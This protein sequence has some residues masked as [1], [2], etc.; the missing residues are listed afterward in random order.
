MIFALDL[1]AVLHHLAL[2]DPLHSEPGSERGPSFFHR[3]ICVVEDRRAG[4]PEL[5]RS[6]ARPRQAVVVAAD[7]G[8]VLWRPH[9]DKLEL[10][11]VAHMRLE[12]F[13][14]LS[15]ITGRPA[16]TIDLAQ[17]VLCRYLAVLD[18]DILEHQVREAKLAGEHVHRVVVV[19]RFKDRLDDL[20]APL[21]RTVR[22]SARAIHLE[23]GAGW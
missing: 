9:R 1:L 15:A 17:E 4:V 7:F 23:A 8:V 5:R 11:L 16:A 19:L 18:L 21:Q 2:D 6:P 3:K 13:G 14:R 10:G 22:S 12:P 20:L